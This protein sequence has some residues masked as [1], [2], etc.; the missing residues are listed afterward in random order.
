[1]SNFKMC[2]RDGGLFSTNH[3]GWST[4]TLTIHREYADKSKYEEKSVLD[5]CPECTADMTG[6]DKVP[7]ALI[8]GE[9][10][11]DLPRQSDRL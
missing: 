4:A 9:T 7:M 3:V 2:D 5:F 6:G 11:A 10:R 8:P 1:M